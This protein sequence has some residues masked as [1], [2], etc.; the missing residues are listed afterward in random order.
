MNR[1]CPPPQPGSCSVHGR[2]PS[3][4]GQGRRKAKINP[5]KQTSR[6]PNGPFHRPPDELRSAI[7]PVGDD[8]TRRGFS[9]GR[10]RQSRHFRMVS[11]LP[12][13]PTVF[14][15]PCATQCLGSSALLFLEHSSSVSAITASRF[16]FICRPDL[17]RRRRAGAVYI[18]VHLES[19]AVCV[20]DT[21]HPSPGGYRNGFPRRA[22][23]FLRRRLGGWRWVHTRTGAPQLSLCRQKWWLGFGEEGLRHAAPR[24][25]SVLTAAP[26]TFGFGDRGRREKLE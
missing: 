20:V 3:K 13:L 12:E 7:R 11:P 9:R 23:W 2:G 22:P 1:K 8:W 18:V 19:T 10:G 16:Q 14:P 24:D 6:I 25:R 15:G 5:Q 21:L 17:R 4:R 26:G